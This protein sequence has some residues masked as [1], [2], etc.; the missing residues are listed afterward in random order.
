MSAFARAVARRDR[1]SCAWMAEFADIENMKSAARL[2]H[3]RGHSS[4]EMY[5]PYPDEEA[6]FL[7]MPKRALLRW[8]V[9][10]GG[11]AGAVTGYL[12]Q[13]YCNAVSYPID[14]GA[15][16]L[17]SAP[18]FVFI[19]FETTVLFASVAAFVGLVFSARLGRLWDPVFE[20]EGFE[21]ATIDRFWIEMRTDKDEMDAETRRILDDYGCLRVILSRD[22]S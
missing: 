14:V 18:A 19:T 21:R 16:P 17:N 1:P 11:L 13:W 4:V 5:L 9:F 3:A 6:E 20:I 22:S 8:A 12:V 2:L 15:R 7:A 10:A